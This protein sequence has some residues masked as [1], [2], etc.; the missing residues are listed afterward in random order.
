MRLPHGVNCKFAATDFTLL[1][2]REYRIAMNVPRK[3]GCCANTLRRFHSRLLLSLVYVLART[4]RHGNRLP[5]FALPQTS[6]NGVPLLNSSSH[7]TSPKFAAFLVNI[8][9]AKWVF[10]DDPKAGITLCCT[11]TW[12]QVKEHFRD[13][14]LRP[15]P[16]L[17]PP[18]R[19][20]NLDLSY[21]AQYQN[22]NGRELRRQVWANG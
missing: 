19:P 15:V 11:L 18:R 9:W 4:T 17:L 2:C 22:S 10:S 7:V 3:A 14:V 16:K 13:H 6:L 5:V 12:A 21:P 8:S 20:E 1:L